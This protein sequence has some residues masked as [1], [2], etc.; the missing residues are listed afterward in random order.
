M[1]DAAREIGISQTGFYGNF[2]SFFLSTYFCAIRAAATREMTIDGRL[3][4]SWRQRRLRRTINLNK[5]LLA[6]TNR[7]GLKSGEDVRTPLLAAEERPAKD[8]Q[9]QRGNMYV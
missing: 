1:V 9:R 8:G 7:R 4:A 6:I 5:Y 3:V 2:S